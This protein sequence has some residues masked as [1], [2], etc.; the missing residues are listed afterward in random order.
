MIKGGKQSDP[1]LNYRNMHKHKIKLQEGSTANLEKCIHIALFQDAGMKLFL[2]S[3]FS[4][5]SL[6][7]KIFGSNRV[8]EACLINSL[9]KFTNSFQIKPI[10]WLEIHPAEGNFISI[11]V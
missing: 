6:Q 11:S 1:F 4:P 2:T 5:F 8:F 7:K 3:H 10:S 9:H